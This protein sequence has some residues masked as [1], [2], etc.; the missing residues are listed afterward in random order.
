MA[1]SITKQNLNTDHALHVIALDPKVE[2]MLLESIQK[3]EL[4]KKLSSI[5][6]CPAE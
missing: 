5:P 2:E 6:R 4:G 1:R 3:S